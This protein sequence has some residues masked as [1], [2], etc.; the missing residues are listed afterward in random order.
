MHEPDLP[1]TRPERRAERLGF[2]LRDLAAELVDERRKVAQ[3]RHQVA[4]LQAQLESLEQTQR[5]ASSDLGTG[6]IHPG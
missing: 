1:R 6:F 4:D 3:L 5:A 2:A